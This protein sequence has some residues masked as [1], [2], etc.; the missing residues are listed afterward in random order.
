MTDR[1]RS[2]RLS[3][4]RG[5]G[6]ANEHAKLHVQQAEMSS[7]QNSFMRRV[8]NCWKQRKLNP[9]NPLGEEVV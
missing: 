4:S 6:H 9:L 7:K 8:L 2:Q 5:L 3:K 1:Q